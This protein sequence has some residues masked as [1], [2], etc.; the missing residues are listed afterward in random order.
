MEFGKISVIKSSFFSLFQRS[1]Q[2]NP[3]MGSDGRYT[4]CIARKPCLRLIFYLVELH[5]PPHFDFG[6][7]KN[8]EVAAKLSITLYY[9]IPS[10]LCGL[11]L[12]KTFT[13]NKKIL[14]IKSYYVSEITLDIRNKIN[15]LKEEWTIGTLWG[16]VQFF[17]DHRTSKF[18]KM[19]CNS[20]K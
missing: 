14:D 12:P 20:N 8:T 11:N 1:K 5:F 4:L 18:L 3:R 19:K 2:N 15:V 6:Y 17:S 9:I 7:S 13:R 16:Q 10:I